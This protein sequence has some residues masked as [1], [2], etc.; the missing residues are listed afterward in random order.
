MRTA[1]FEPATNGWKPPMLPLTPCSLYVWSWNRTNEPK[2]CLSLASWHITT[3]S[4]RH[5]AAT[6]GRTEMRKR[7]G[8]KPAGLPLPNS[9]IL[10]YSRLMKPL[11]NLLRPLRELNSRLLRDREVF[12]HYTKRAFMDPRGVEPL[13]HPCKG[14][15]LPLYDE[16]I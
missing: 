12:Y 5:Y 9:G 7:A 4:S 3:L 15:I 11:T 13:S 10:S 16:P 6:P 14:Y 1:G 2:G 8:F